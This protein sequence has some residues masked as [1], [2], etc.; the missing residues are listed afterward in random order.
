LTLAV[1]NAGDERPKSIE[2]AEGVTVYY[3]QKTPP[4]PRTEFRIVAMTVGKEET[5]EKELNRLSQEG[6][7]LVTTTQPLANDGKS[8]PTSIHFLLKR[9]V[10]P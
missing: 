3:F 6:Y 10:T 1:A 5:A 8:A 9:T 2:Q 7:E 4:P